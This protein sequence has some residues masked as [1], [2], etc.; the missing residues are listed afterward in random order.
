[1]KGI[2]FLPEM[3]SVSGT[4]GID[5]NMIESRDGRDLDKVLASAGTVQILP[6]EALR[7][8][9]ATRKAVETTLLS[10]GTR[11]FGGFL[12]DESNSSVV[13]AELAKIKAGFDNARVRL[14]AGLPQIIEDRVKEA[15]EWED[16]IRG[17]A[18]TVDELAEAISFTWI[19]TP[20]DL[21]DPEVEE[22]LKGDPLAIRIAREMAQTASS[23]L[24]KTPVG[25][26]GIS[27]LSVL[28][29]LRAKAQALSF[30]DGRLGGL[31]TAIDTV[32]RDANATKGTPA[33]AGAS[34]VVKGVVQALTSP[35]T[36]LNVGEDGQFTDLPDMLPPEPESPVEA[37]ETECEANDEADMPVIP[38]VKRDPA[39][40]VPV[41]SWAF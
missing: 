18:P 19:K 11:F 25:T 15:P 17:Y 4:K 12:V 24:T 21:S 35:A 7:P 31:V 13:N 34:L 36:I 16:I 29:Q 23:W 39:P 8:F 37:V 5:R 33:Q 30:V 10:R 9:G 32:I 3:K 26:K 20:V 40:I 41:S 28:A 27:G 38:S 6:K 22:V 1:M 2:V 14:M